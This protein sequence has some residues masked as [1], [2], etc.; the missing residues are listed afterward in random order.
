[1]SLLGSYESTKL[2]TKD[3][4]RNVNTQAAHAKIQKN[5]DK[6]A[7]EIFP[8]IERIKNEGLR[9]LT[10]IANRLNAMRIETCQ[11]CHWTPMAVQ[12]ILARKPSV[13]PLEDLLTL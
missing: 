11:G 8:E 5:A 6:F 4:S 1:M 9:T 10:A 13:D 12:R 2:P 3:P 7:R